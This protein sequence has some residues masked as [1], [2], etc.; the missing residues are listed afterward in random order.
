[1]HLYGF[2]DSGQGHG[3]SSSS[4]A[5]CGQGHQA[6]IRD[7]SRTNQPHRLHDLPVVDPGVGTYQQ[8]LPRLPHRAGQY[9]AQAVRCNLVGVQKER[10]V[11]GAIELDVFS[12]LEKPITA[13]E[14]SEKM[15]WDKGKQRDRKSVV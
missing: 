14:L 5:V 6:Y 11:F 8:L 4:G 1:M 2:A 9:R 10:A 3:R 7:T 15:N 12:N 13:K